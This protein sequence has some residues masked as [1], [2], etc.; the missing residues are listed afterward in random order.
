MKGSYVIHG[1]WVSPWTSKIY[2]NP[3]KLDVDHTVPLAYAHKR[4][5]WRW[6]SKEKEFFANDSRNLQVVEAKL[7]REKSAGGLL[8]FLPPQNQCQYI[9]RFHRIMKTY[10]LEYLS[11]EERE[12]KKLISQC[13]SDGF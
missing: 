8:E 7:N 4:G 1:R 10:K 5:G 11:Q 6:T 9:F 3:R 13:K 2:T 12:I